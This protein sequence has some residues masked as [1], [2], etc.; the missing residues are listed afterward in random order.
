MEESYEVELVEVSRSF[1]EVAAVDSVSL[2][3]RSGEF[4]TL[5]G[6]SGCGKTTLLRLIAGFER[7]DRGRVLLGGED[8]SELPPYRRDVTTVFQ[9]Y[10]LFPH[11]NV[12]DNVAFGLE[13]RRVPRSKIKEHV[14][15]A[16]ELVRMNGLE[17]RRPAELSGGQ[18]QRVALARALVLAPRVLLLDEPLAALDLKLRKQ[19]QL[20]LKA[21]QRRLGISFVFVTH[22]QEEALTMSDRVAVMN[23]GKI[24]QSGSAE[25][26]Y[27]RPRT[28]FVASFIGISNIIEG[29]IIATD[30]QV[31]VVGLQHTEVRVRA[32]NKKI[33]E[34]V[35]IMIRPEKIKLSSNGADGAISGRI[36]QGVYLGESTQWRVRLDG[37]QEITVMEQNREPS[38]AISSRIGQTVSISWETSSA[39]VLQA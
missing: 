9:Q 22:D 27:E 16:L 13:R 6:P 7:T 18:Q 33:G 3:I 17:Q 35:R 37:G 38:L 39:V 36:E 29:T 31:S 19:M 14:S 4:L 24:E 10:A 32:T 21:I 28:E 1:G 26:I 2:G 12:F 15:N 25:E 34:R 5:L 11:L 30:D 20:E 8:V 23:A